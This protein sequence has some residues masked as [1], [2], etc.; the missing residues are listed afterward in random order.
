MIGIHAPTVLAPIK[1]IS[2]LETLDASRIYPQCNLSLSI[3]SHPT[4]YWAA[5]RQ[6]RHLRDIRLLVLVIWFPGS[7][8]RFQPLIK[9]CSA[10]AGIDNGDENKYD[11]DDGKGR[12]RLSDWYIILHLRR[13][14]P[15]SD[16]FEEEVGKA[17][18]IQQLCS[19]ESVIPLKLLKRTGT[20]YDCNHPKF[21]F[22]LSENC[23][24]E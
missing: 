5:M 3:N 23:C 24:H 18:E 10:D 6:V 21:V 7:K 14:M 11:G 17:S 1:V 22:S 9:V 12:H 15:H 13:G 19:S 16:E 20:N 2:D 4:R 8:V